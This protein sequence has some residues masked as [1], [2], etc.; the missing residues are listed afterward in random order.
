MQKNRRNARLFNLSGSGPCE[1]LA[2]ATQ[3]MYFQ[4]F[5]PKA[6]CNCFLFK[7][8]CS[9]K[10]QMSFILRHTKA[11]N[12]QWFSGNRNRAFVISELK[13]QHL[14]LCGTLGRKQSL[15]LRHPLCNRLKRCFTRSNT[16]APN[17]STTYILAK[18]IWT[19]SCF[20]YDPLSGFWN[21]TH[22][23]SRQKR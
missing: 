5:L 20:Q 4:I 15:V 16:K 12:R 11:T 13:Q 22:K 2:S 17:F 23:H 6:A 10:R 3:K 7:Y 1:L 18:H 8:L 21:S 14:P 9:S 19:F